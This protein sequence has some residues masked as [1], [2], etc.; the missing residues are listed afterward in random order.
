M[1]ASAKYILPRTLLVE[2]E[3]GILKNKGTDK[4]KAKVK[5]KMNSTA[6]EEWTKFSPW[7]KNK[8]LPSSLI[9]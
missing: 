9:A 3:K 8:K 7:R 4:G 6:R 5:G 2:A 1:A